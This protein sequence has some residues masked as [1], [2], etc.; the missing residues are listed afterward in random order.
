MTGGEQI[1]QIFDEPKSVTLLDPK[2]SQFAQRLYDQVRPASEFQPVLDQDYVVKGW[3]NRDS[4]SVVY[5][6][7]NVGK[8]FWAVDL[9]HHVQQGLEWAGCRVTAGPVLYVAAEGGMLFANRLAAVKAQFM[10]LQAPLVLGGRNC[11]AAFLVQAIKRLSDVHGPF[12]LIIFDTLARVM[13]GDENAAPDVAALVRGVDT[14]RRETGAHIMLIHHSGK[15]VTKGARGHSALRAAVDTEIELTKS[16]ETGERMA[17]ATKQRDMACDAE[18]L[19][20]LQQVK[21]GPDQDGD[22]VTSCVIKH[23][24]ERA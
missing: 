18:C 14:L 16:K 4:V 24:G 10:V 13:A 22:P 8:S 5:G 12:A 17:R 19:F 1:R 23:L 6:E 21:L 20:Q 11:N 2:L 3:L 15:D 9:A 7:P